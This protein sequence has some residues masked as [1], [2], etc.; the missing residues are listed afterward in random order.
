MMDYFVQNNP[1]VLNMKDYKQRNTKN[2]N[3][4]NEETVIKS[5]SFGH[6]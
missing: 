1:A 5:F 6:L 3:N 4:K 2:C